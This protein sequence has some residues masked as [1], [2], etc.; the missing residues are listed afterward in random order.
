VSDFLLAEFS[1]SR[2]ARDAARKA[3]LAG[4]P[5]Q[6]VLSCVPLEGVVDD[7]APR[8]R[9]PIG[10]V[11]AVAGAIGAAIGW[12]MQWYS[13]VIDYPTN[14]GG[15]PLDSWPAFLLVPY[16][17]TIL[18]AGVVG[19]LGW[20]WMCGLPKLFHPLFEAALTKRAVQDKW[21]L[22]F[23][24]DDALARWVQAHLKPDA[25]HEVRQ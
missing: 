9:G 25:V 21:V 22:V 3:A 15:R 11:M 14:S 2:T 8:Q 18:A 24:H 10:W 1:D 23:A 17:T 20:M 16:E 6:D 4:R 13:A 5:A 7:L 19:L 12:F